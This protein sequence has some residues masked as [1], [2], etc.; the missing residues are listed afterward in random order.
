MV[1]FGEDDKICERAG[2]THRNRRVPIVHLQLIS[3]TTQT[4]SNSPNFTQMAL[5]DHLNHVN[6]PNPTPS[7]HTVDPASSTTP[8]VTQLKSPVNQ[9]SLDPASSNLYSPVTPRAPCVPPPVSTRD[10]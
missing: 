3:L 7:P 8:S 6:T 1:T 10:K 9:F 4:L 5:T 2:V